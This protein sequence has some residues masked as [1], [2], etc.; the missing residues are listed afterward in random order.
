M[1]RRRAYTPTAHTPT[2]VARA[3]LPLPSAERYGPLTDWRSD[4]QRPVRSGL[5]VAAI[6]SISPRN[7]FL[8]CSRRLSASRRFPPSHSRTREIPALQNGY[9]PPIV[10]D[11]GTLADLRLF[12]NV[13]VTT[14][15][16]PGSPDCDVP[17][18]KA[19][20]TPSVSAGD[21]ASHRITIEV[22]VADVG[23]VEPSD[24]PPPPAA[25]PGTTTPDVPGPV[26]SANATMAFV[27]KRPKALVTIL[28][29]QLVPSTPP[30]VTG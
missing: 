5:V 14:A 13:T 20:G 1:S 21:L 19:A 6:R 28:A 11:G 22:N 27:V 26:V 3:R 8:D 29:R 2:V 15:N 16:G 7:V 25:P 17:V 18:A 9:E 30:P 12:D 23:P 24:F 4:A 10:T